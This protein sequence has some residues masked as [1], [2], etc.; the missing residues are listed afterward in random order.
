M[1]VN[2]YPEF[3]G[4]SS[5]AESVF[6]TETWVRVLQE[7]HGGYGR[8]QCSNREEPRRGVGIRFVMH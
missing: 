3:I 2:R 8:N 7:E 1:F 6:V 5:F 4:L